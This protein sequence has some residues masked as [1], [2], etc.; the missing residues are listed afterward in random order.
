MV[1]V[2]ASVVVVVGASVVVVVGASVVVVVGTSVVDVVGASVVLV[3]RAFVVPQNWPFFLQA[4][5][6]VFD[7]TCTA[8][9]PMS[10]NI[11][12]HP[13]GLTMKPIQVVAIEH[14]KIKKL[15]RHNQQG[16]SW[17]VRSILGGIQ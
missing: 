12:P 5:V 9:G 4:V 2:G 11:T 15:R 8:R 16:W 7:V 17:I 3:V 10:G 14:L 13:R 6:V 1:V